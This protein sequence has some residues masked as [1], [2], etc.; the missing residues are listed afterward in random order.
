MGARAGSPLAILTARK[1]S[2][3]RGKKGKV[4]LLEKRE[5]EKKPKGELTIA[6]RPSPLMQSCH[7]SSVRGKR[8]ERETR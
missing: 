8:C 2:S 5:D 7:V 4:T 3:R 6:E 1:S